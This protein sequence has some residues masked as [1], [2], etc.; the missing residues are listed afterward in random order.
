MS[1]HLSR[2]VFGIVGLWKAIFENYARLLP[3]VSLAHLWHVRS[4]SGLSILKDLWDFA[5]FVK[6]LSSRVTSL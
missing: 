2:S 1:D 5:Q 4:V 6:L 3:L